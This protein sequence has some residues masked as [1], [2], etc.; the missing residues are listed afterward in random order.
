MPAKKLPTKR[1]SKLT[2]AER[3]ARFVE[4]AH[5]VGASDDPKAF[6][7]AFEKIAASKRGKE[8]GHG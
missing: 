5:K 7:E 1:K 8:S 3:H 6:D 4:V 2:D